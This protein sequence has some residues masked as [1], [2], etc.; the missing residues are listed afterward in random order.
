MTEDLVIHKAPWPT[1]WYVTQDAVRGVLFRKRDS[2]EHVKVEPPSAW[3]RRWSWN[4][5]EDGSGVYFR[6]G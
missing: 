4:L 1:D 6:N 3:G 2:G 5:T